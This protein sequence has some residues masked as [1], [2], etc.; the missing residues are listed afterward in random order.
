MKEL[1]QKNSSMQTLEQVAVVKL[2]SEKKSM[3]FHVLMEADM[4]K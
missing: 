2:S 3:I 1:I 4:I